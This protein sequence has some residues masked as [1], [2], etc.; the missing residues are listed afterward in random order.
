MILLSAKA[1]WLILLIEHAS[2][3]G[4]ASIRTGIS[5]GWQKTL[6]S[7]EQVHSQRVL[8]RVLKG[9]L[10]KKFVEQTNRAL[11]L[12]CKVEAYDTEGKY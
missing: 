5:I 2:I 8:K 6:S 10:R 7:L 11:H 4:S 3:P 9:F 1:V 12:R